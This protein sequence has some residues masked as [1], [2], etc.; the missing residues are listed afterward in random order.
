MAG[1]RRE[2]DM[3][4][5]RIVVAHQF[6]LPSFHDWKQNTGEAAMSAAMINVGLMRESRFP[7]R[8]VTAHAYACVSAVATVRVIAV[9]P[10][11]AG[12]TARR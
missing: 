2:A 9:G 1:S 6:G 4:V 5:K 8:N 12:F 11:I 7:I 3:V 10:R